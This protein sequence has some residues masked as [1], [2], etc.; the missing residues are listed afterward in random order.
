[1]KITNKTQTNT[2]TVLIKGED[3]LVDLR[4]GNWNEYP[5]FREFLVQCDTLAKQDSRAMFRTLEVEFQIREAAKIQAEL[6]NLLEEGVSAYDDICLSNIHQEIL[7][8]LMD[9]FQDKPLPVDG[10]DRCACGAKYWDWI[11]CAS[12]GETFFPGLKEAL[13]GR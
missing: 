8:A 4:L 6:F 10:V 2:I 13:L 11:Y 9:F 12:C 1:M 7:Q 5:T 3:A